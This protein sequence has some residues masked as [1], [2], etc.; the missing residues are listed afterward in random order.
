MLS[1]FSDW[2]FVV[3]ESQQNLFNKKIDHLISYVVG[4]FGRGDFF[5]NTAYVF[6]AAS[7]KEIKIV[8]WDGSGFSVWR[9]KLKAKKQTNFKLVNLPISFA[10]FSMTLNGFLC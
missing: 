2:K 7:R 6:V 10:D 9:K 1:C 4:C 3:V 5:S 8:F